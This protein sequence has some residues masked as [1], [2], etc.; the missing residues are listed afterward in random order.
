MFLLY[1]EL[2]PVSERNQVASRPVLMYDA[3]SGLRPFDAACGGKR[4][5]TSQNE[6]PSPG[7]R[8][9]ITP[10]ASLSWREAV[11]F[12]LGISTVSLTIAVSLAVQ[13]LWLV[14]PFSGLELLA[15]GW[16]LYHVGLRNRSREIISIEGD[17]IYIRR[18]NRVGR[19]TQDLKLRRAWVSVVMQ[20]PEYRGHPERLLLRSHGDEVEVGRI[21]TDDE[22]KELARALRQRLNLR[23][24]NALA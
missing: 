16:A 4:V 6:E 2:S 22:R 17:T 10:N 5:V 7:C 19:R 13:G 3:P 21:L 12:F 18:E 15:L 24:A 11:I 20:P 14:L 1:H 9:E 8:F 23:P